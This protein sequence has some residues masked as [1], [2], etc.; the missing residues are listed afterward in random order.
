MFELFAFLAIVILGVLLSDTRARLKRAEKTLAEAVGQFGAAQGTR[1]AP[2]VEARPVAE[3]Q[4][5]TTPPKAARAAS[6]DSAPLP[7]MTQKQGQTAS[8]PAGIEVRPSPPPVPASK[9]PAAPA[10][11]P[12]NGSRIGPAPFF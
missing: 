11:P 2:V 1:K 9:T 8:A 12:Q 5:E 7:A 6:R 3:P 4:S 10:K